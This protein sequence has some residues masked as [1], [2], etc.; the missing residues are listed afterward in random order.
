LRDKLPHDKTIVTNFCI[1]PNFDDTIDGDSDLGGP[2]GLSL[3]G[4]ARLSP[5]GAF[6][7]VATGL[8]D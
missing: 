4:T 2:G 5:S 8:L 3:V 6:V 7:D 1:P